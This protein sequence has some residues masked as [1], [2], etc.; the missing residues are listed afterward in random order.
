M[1]YSS[2]YHSSNNSRSPHMF[3]CKYG[4]RMAYPDPLIWL[5]SKPDIPSL[6]SQWFCLT[7]RKNHITA[8][9]TELLGIIHTLAIHS[10]RNTNDKAV[11]PAPRRMGTRLTS[12][13]CC[14]LCIQPALLS[15]GRLEAERLPASAGPPSVGRAAS[16]TPSSPLYGTGTCCL[17]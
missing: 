4:E 5:K 2:F 17:V 8:D 3:Y 13:T 11:N 7:V 12:L 14:W 1:E 10:S 16:L 9:I 15:K 6:Q